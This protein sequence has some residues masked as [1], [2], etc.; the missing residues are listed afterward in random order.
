M[1]ITAFLFPVISCC[2]TMSNK[3][4]RPWGTHCCESSS[5]VFP[6][7]GCTFRLRKCN[8]FSRSAWMKQLWTGLFG[9]PGI[10]CGPEGGSPRPWTGAAP[11]STYKYNDVYKYL[12]SPSIT[13]LWDFICIPLMISLY[14]ILSPLFYLSLVNWV[15]WY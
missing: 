12:F 14:T 5:I 13:R 15:L 1:T 2:S 3:S 10:L 4:S 11:C 6:G 7:I 9:A 8:A